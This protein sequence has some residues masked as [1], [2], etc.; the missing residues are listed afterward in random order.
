MCLKQ[1]KNAAGAGI[2]VMEDFPLLIL[3]LD[4][5]LGLGCCTF[6]VALRLALFLWLTLI[7]SSRL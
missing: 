2:L 5:R 3:V 4:V 1:R 7:I 6:A